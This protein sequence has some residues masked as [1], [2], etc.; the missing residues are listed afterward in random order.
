V[1][2]A[3]VVQSGSGS[4]A[5]AVIGGGGV[6][7]IGQEE[8]QEGQGCGAVGQRQKTGWI[9]R[10]GHRGERSASFCLVSSQKH[11]SRTAEDASVG[12]L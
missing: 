8:C 5:E 7:R 1:V 6:Y 11:E 4:V 2:G 3:E 10:G 9:E 12:T